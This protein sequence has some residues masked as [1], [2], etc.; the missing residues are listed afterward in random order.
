MSAAPITAPYQAQAQEVLTRTHRQ[1][2][3]A[4]ITSGATVQQLEISDGSVAL[5]EDWSPHQKFTVTSPALAAL[6]AV[7]DPRQPVKIEVLAG[8]VYP[9]GGGEDVHVLATGHIRSG[10]QDTPGDGHT[11]ECASDELRTLDNKWMG[12]RQTKSYAGVLEA[13]TWL[14]GHAC[15][16]P[17]T[18]EAS[19]G[20]AHRADLVAAVVLEPGKPLWDQ[21]Y[22]ISLAAG[23]WVY[24]DTTGTWRLE[25]RPTAATEA[26]VLLRTGPNSLVKKS[27]HSQDLEPYYTA[28][29]LQYAWKDAGGAD[30]EIFGTW[31][32]TPGPGQD[33]GA[34]HKVFY[35]SR[36]VQTD[37]FSADEAAR[38]TVAQLSTR[39]DSYT[40]EAVA[41]Y[42]LR[43]GHTAAIGDAGIRHIVKTVTFDLGAGTMTLATREPSNLGE[44]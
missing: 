23:L 43:P 27:G 22:A 16:T 14:V 4:R 44:N 1:R 10:T 26:A 37:Q 29:V 33:I 8:Y 24:V 30:R 2:V 12:P 19:I 36:A 31:A 9:A 20:M 21:I 7:A 42:W 3:Y 35:A 40:I 17:Q 41:A 32:P 13:I 5:S 39:G 18:I 15:P 34:G 38:L 11:M 25:P 6:V 28:A